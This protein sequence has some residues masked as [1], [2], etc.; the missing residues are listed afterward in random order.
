[1]TRRYG[2]VGHHSLVSW[3][4]LQSG[5][6]SKIASMFAVVPRGMEDPLKLLLLIIFGGGLLAFGRWSSRLGSSTRQDS[7]LDIP[8][9]DVAG[10]VPLGGTGASA[11][12]PSAEEVAAS[13]PYD[14]ALGNLRIRKFYFNKADAIPGPDDP[15]VFADELNV[16][17]YDPESG[18]ASWQSYFVATPQGLSNLLREKSWRYLH[19]PQVLVFPH[20]DLE[21]I[22][23]AVV[24]RVVAD[25]EL[26]KSSE[27]PDEE[28]L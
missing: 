16:E 15:E 2:V 9:P 6:Q 3:S 20:Y 7:P 4:T 18:H 14:P 26:L 21:E 8:T 17:L 10:L 19:A 12:P 11:R 25:H 28:A 5:Q 23:R 22:R 1:M 27:W 13:L 24:S